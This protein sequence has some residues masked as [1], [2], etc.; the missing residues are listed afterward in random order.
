[1]K[2]HLICLFVCCYGLAKCQ[3]NSNKIDSV[4]LEN[5]IYVI[6]M[7]IWNSSFKSEYKNV[8]FYN[9]TKSKGVIIHYDTNDRIIDT[10]LILKSDF[11]LISPKIENRILFRS[12]YDDFKDT[13]IKKGT[14][15]SHSGIILQKTTFNYEKSSLHYFSE[16][17]FLGDLIVMLGIS[18][19]KYNL[20][21]K[22]YEI[23]FNEL[24]CYKSIM[25]I[26]IKNR[27]RNKK[28][29]HFYKGEIEKL[30]KIFEDSII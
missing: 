4:L 2:L 20:Q 30:N 14:P 27:G 15:Y 26:K 9:F 22:S 29:N 23:L 25:K 8:I 7:T 16:I 18:E 10:S 28:K 21:N 5:D 12:F 24:I 11:N 6:D 19:S 1:M 3:I 17:E 13:T